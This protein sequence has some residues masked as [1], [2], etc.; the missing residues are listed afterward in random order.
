M[1]EKQIL[2][3]IND[4]VSDLEVVTRMLSR[5]RVEEAKEYG[6]ELWV[7]VYRAVG[8]SNN[9]EILAAQISFEKQY[10]IVR[11]ELVNA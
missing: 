11:Q 4:A 5:G 3:K 2:T 6:A 9:Q 10:A 7:G 8:F 1:T